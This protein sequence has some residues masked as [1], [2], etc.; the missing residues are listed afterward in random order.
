MTSKTKP[1]LRM[2]LSPG[3][4][5]PDTRLVQSEEGELS[6]ERHKNTVTASTDSELLICVET[7][8][9]WVRIWTS[10]QLSKVQKLGIGLPAPVGRQSCFLMA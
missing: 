8:G 10:L 4:T 6:R 9:Q 2:I 3:T 7:T 5:C 1:K